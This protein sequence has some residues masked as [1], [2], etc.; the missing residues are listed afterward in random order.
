MPC[1][2]LVPWSGMEPMP[3]QWKYRVLTTGSPGKS[4][5][6]SIFLFFEH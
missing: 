6:L 3:E 1:G 5:F 2:I 4:L